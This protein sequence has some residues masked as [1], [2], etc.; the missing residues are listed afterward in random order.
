MSYA[1]VAMV[2]DYDCWRDPG[3]A[4]NIDM[5]LDVMRKNIGTMKALVVK[6]VEE[7]AREDWTDTIKANRIRAEASV[8]NH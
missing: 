1:S 7:L 5:V 6:A 3:K 8:M 4:V 2:T